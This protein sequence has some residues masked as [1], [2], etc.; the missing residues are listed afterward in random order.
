MSR[1]DPT[2]CPERE[3]GEASGS[4]VR[5][6]PKKQIYYGI[7]GRT[8]NSTKDR[9][10]HCRTSVVI[11][12]KRQEKRN[13]TKTD[14][15]KERGEEE[16]EEKKLL[17]HERPVISEIVCHF[18]DASQMNWTYPELVRLQMFHND[19]PEDLRRGHADEIMSFL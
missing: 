19:N 11:G 7:S 15:S 6:S 16:K 14:K 8:K 5:Y 10:R 4:F 3:R 1:R 13:W 17:F 12:K 18:S 9:R 2:E